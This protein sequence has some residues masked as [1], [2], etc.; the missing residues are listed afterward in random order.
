MGGMAGVVFVY[1]NYRVP[2]CQRVAELSEPDAIVADQGLEDDDEVDSTIQG[3]FAKC[4]IPSITLEL[5]SGNEWHK[6]TIQRGI[7]YIHRLMVDMG[8]LHGSE[9]PYEPDL[10]NTVVA[11]TEHSVPA[12]YSGWV[13]MLIAP[14]EFVTEGQRLANILNSWGDLLEEVVAPVKGMVLYTAWHPGMEAGG[15][16]AVL[17]C[18]DEKLRDKGK[19]R[20]LSSNWPDD[21]QPLRAC[22]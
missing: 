17:V 8:I 7:A 6:P 13:D 12:R 5:G 4:G 14:G 21:L 9:S 11:G 22:I 18:N 19:A 15:T 3:A 20:A 2:F 16:V 10:S 1:A